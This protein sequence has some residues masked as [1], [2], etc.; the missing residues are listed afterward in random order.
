MCVGGSGRSGRENGWDRV[1]TKS[2]E[3]VPEPETRIQIWTNGVRHLVFSLAAANRSATFSRES[4]WLVTPLRLHRWSTLHNSI[5]RRRDT[6]GLAIQRPQSGN[7]SGHSR[8]AIGGILATFLQETAQDASE[9]WNLPR[10][11]TPY[12]GI[13]ATTKAGLRLTGGLT[14][15]LCMPLPPGAWLH[16]I[17]SIRILSLWSLASLHRPL[18]GHIMLQLFE[19]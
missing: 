10:N 3:L 6:W 19:G 11:L 15:R 5:R 4:F 16:S 2:R 14:R 17:S 7:A 8:R 9:T 1:K 18:R 12:S 13:Q